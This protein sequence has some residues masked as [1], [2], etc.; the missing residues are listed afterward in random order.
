[1]QEKLIRFTLFL[2]A[3][4]V[5]VISFALMLSILIEALK[6]FRQESL[7]TFLFSSQ[8]SADTAFIRAD[9]STGHGVFGAA[10][11]FWGSFYISLIA[12][13][14]AL[15]LGIMSALYLSVYAGK[16]SKTY[17][18]SILELIAAIP[19]VVFGFFALILISPFI[20]F[21]C[22]NLGLEASYESAL[23]AGFIMGIM[24][25]PIIASLSQDCLEAVSLKRINAAYAL[26]MSKKE[27]IFAVILPEAMPGIIA[28]CLLALSKALGETM[29]V[30]MA[31]SLRPN[32]SLNFLEDMTSVTVHIVQALQGDQ[33]FDSP[34]ALSAF[35]LGLALFIITFIIN[36]ISV[37]LIDKFNK[38]KNL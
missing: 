10:S 8:W 32:M 14:V 29:I 22:R 34:L 24:I 26:G 30:V 31:A 17:F 35:S 2:C 1:M 7:F 19:S 18:K 6:F 5:V 20:V 36:M 33:A 21:M 3:F 25:S 16:K 15:P 11:L 27:V 13:L 12:M 38:G 23:G 28:A 4:T 9:G 37:Y